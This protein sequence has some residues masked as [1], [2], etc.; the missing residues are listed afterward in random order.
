MLVIPE[1]Y[2][3]DCQFWDRRDTV[4]GVLCTNATAT[5]YDHIPFPQTLF[6][7]RADH[8]Q[9]WTYSEP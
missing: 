3:D 7:P 6:R 5:S 4:D 8:L 9:R 1:R 2:P